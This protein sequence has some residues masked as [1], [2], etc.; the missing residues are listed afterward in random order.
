MCVAFCIRIAL[1]RE[2]WERGQIKSFCCIKK[3]NSSK[4]GYY[5]FQTPGLRCGGHD[6]EEII[7]EAEC[8]APQLGGRSQLN[9]GSLPEH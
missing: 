2:V 8:L 3:R 7:L 5:D 1:Q 4:R 6:S 9:P